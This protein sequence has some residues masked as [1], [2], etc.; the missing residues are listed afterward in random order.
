[1]ID[2]KLF[3]SEGKREINE[4]RA[5]IALHD[6]SYCFAV[7]DGLGGHGN[8]EIAAQAAID[9][10][11]ELFVEEGYSNEFFEHAFVA[12]QRSIIAEQ[13]R[14]SSPSKMKTTLV[15]LV[16][17][18]KKA[19]WAHVGDTR[20]YWFKNNRLKVR[21]LDHSVPQMLAISGE[22][23]E[24]DIRH[25]PD[26]NRLMR[27][28]GLHGETPNYDVSKEVKLSG[29]CSFLLCTDGFWELIEENEMES[30]LKSCSTAALWIEEM[31]DKVMQNGQ[32]SEMDNF[33]AIAV[34]AK[35][36]TLLERLI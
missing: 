4:D 16:I 23:K 8:G 28:M 21:T 27:V 19:I 3:T 18:D 9:A 7:A 31:S 36:K 11:C 2:Y 6:D 35:E 26:R 29:E 34:R 10:V 33:T 30:D 32:G 5:G 14:M 25:H 24:K 15:V 22:I 12:A 1:M 13:D 17:K 20:L